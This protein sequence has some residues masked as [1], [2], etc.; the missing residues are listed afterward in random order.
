[1]FGTLLCLIV[2]LTNTWEWIGIGNEPEE[3]H[4]HL[5]HLH[6]RHRSSHQAW[7]IQEAAGDQKSHRR[8]KA[9]KKHLW[10]ANMAAWVKDGGTASED[11]FNRGHQWSWIPAPGASLNIPSKVNVV[12]KDVYSFP[13]RNIN[14]S[15]IKNKCYCLLSRRVYHN[16]H[17]SQSR[18]LWRI[19]LVAKIQTTNVEWVGGNTPPLNTHHLLT[20]NTPGGELEDRIWNLWR[21]E[22]LHFSEADSSNVYVRFFL[23]FFSYHKWNR[24]KSV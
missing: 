20:V 1:M 12:F 21:I 15:F 16:L 11:M 3:Q 9:P 8:K 22:L 17:L 19:C 5:D 14:E 4:D 7:L 2:W 6:L 18:F 24:I 23:I 13:F 10:C